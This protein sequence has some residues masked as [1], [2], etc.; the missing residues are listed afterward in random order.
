MTEYE[1]LVRWR[2][3]AVGGERLLADL[4][5]GCF[6]SLEF[7]QDGLCYA[8]IGCDGQQPVLIT[9]IFANRAVAEAWVEDKAQLL[10]SGH[11]IR[12]PRA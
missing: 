5:N 7:W 9:D 2:S 4:P 10:A 6:A 12:P 3:A 8:M 1:R 11:P